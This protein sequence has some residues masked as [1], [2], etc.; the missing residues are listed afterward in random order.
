METNVDSTAS[1]GSEPKNGR[2]GKIVFTVSKEKAIET[3]RRH[4]LRVFKREL[5]NF[6]D[7]LHSGYPDS[8]HL[9]FTHVF[10]PSD[11]N[12]IGVNVSGYEKFKELLQKKNASRNCVTTCLNAYFREHRISEQCGLRKE[13]AIDFKF[14]L[15]TKQSPQT[16]SFPI[17]KSK[18][19]TELK[20][21]SFVF[22]HPSD[23]ATDS[24]FIRGSL[25]DLINGQLHGKPM[26]NITFAFTQSEIDE[27]NG[28]IYHYEL[29]KASKLSNNNPE[30]I[31]VDYKLKVESS[32]VHRDCFKDTSGQLFDLISS[33]EYDPNQVCAQVDRLNRYYL[34]SERDRVIAVKAVI[35]RISFASKNMIPGLN[36]FL[37]IERVFKNQYHI[38]ETVFSSEQAAALIAILL[39]MSISDFPDRCQ[40]NMLTISQ[41]VFKI[42]IGSTFSMAAYL[43]CV[44]ESCLGKKHKIDVVE[45]YLKKNPSDRVILYSDQKE[46]NILCNTIF[47]DVLKGI[48]QIWSIF[49]ELFKNLPQENAFNVLVHI[50]RKTEG[51][52]EGNFTNRIETLLPHVFDYVKKYISERSP[53]DDLDSFVDFIWTL[54]TIPGCV[55]DEM[56]GRIEELLLKYL[57]IHRVKCSSKMFEHILRIL[58]SEFVFVASGRKKELLLAMASSKSKLVRDNFCHICHSFKD[59]KVPF[60]DILVSI[61]EETTTQ[62]IITNICELEEECQNDDELLYDIFKHLKWLL[63]SFEQLTY[64]ENK[65]LEQCLSVIKRSTLESIMDVTKSMDTT[66]KQFQSVVDI[67]TKGISDSINDRCHRT[68]TKPCDIVTRMERE[69]KLIID[70]RAELRVV[71]Q[72]IECCSTNHSEDDCFAIFDEQTRHSVFWESI[73]QAEG[74]MSTELHELNVYQRIT[75]AIQDV[76]N[77]YKSREIF[78]DKCETIVKTNVKRLLKI[79][80]VSEDDIKEILDIIKQKKMRTKEY[81]TIVIDFLNCCTARFP[82]LLGINEGL[83]FSQKLMER[84]DTGAMSL[85]DYK[86]KAF[87]E[88][89]EDLSDISSDLFQVVKSDVFWIVNDENISLFVSLNERLEKQSSLEGNVAIDLIQNL[90]EFLGKECL[91]KYQNAWKRLN[92][93][94][95]ITMK[96]V[97]EILETNCEMKEEISIFEKLY[98]PQTLSDDVKDALLNLSDREKLPKLVSA[99]DAFVK[100]FT[101][102]MTGDDRITKSMDI[103]NNF[104]SDVNSDISLSSVIEDLYRVT[105]LTECVNRKT[106]I[107]IQALGKSVRLVDFIRQ[108]DIENVRTLYDAVDYISETNIEKETIK[109][110]QDVVIFLNPILKKITE[111]ISLD[112]ILHDMQDRINTVKDEKLDSKVNDCNSNVYTLTYLYKNVANRE[113]QTIDVI[114]KI[115]QNGMFSFEIHSR[116]STVTLSVYYNDTV[117]QNKIQ[118]G[119]NKMNDLR[120][121]TLLLKNSLN[122]NEHLLNLNSFLSKIETAFEIKNIM[123]AI[124]DS[125][126]TLDPVL[127][128]GSA[129]YSVKRKLSEQLLDWKTKIDHARMQY[130]LL[131]F[132][133]GRK[134]NILIEYLQNKNPHSK[135]D[136]DEVTT[137]LQF[138]Y[139]GFEQIPVDGE[140]CKNLLRKYIPDGRN[141]SFSQIQVF[142]CILA[143]QL[144]RFTLSNFFKVNILKEGNDNL[145]RKSILE[146]IIQMAN[147]IAARPVQFSENASTGVNYVIANL[148]RIERWDQ[149]NPFACVF[150]DSNEQTI[151]VLYRSENELPYNI[152]NLLHHQLHQG[153]PKYTEMTQEQ[154]YD[155]LHRIL[156]TTSEI[157]DDYVLTPDNLLKMTLIMLRIWASVPVVIMGETGCGKTSLI[158]VLAHACRVPCRVFRLHAGIKETKILEF[159]IEENNECKKNPFEQRWLFIDELNTTECIGVISDLI[160]HGMVHGELLAPNLKI[161]GACNPYK[162]RSILPSQAGGINTKLQNDPLSEL[163]YRVVPLPQSVLQYV[164]DF[165]SLMEK[166][167]HEYIHAMV[168]TLC[169]DSEIKVSIVDAITRSQVFIKS[170]KEYT[171]AVSLRDVNRCLKLMHWFYDLQNLLGKNKDEHQAVI[172]ALVLTYQMRFRERCIRQ[173]YEKVIATPFSISGHEVANIIQSAQKAIVSEMEFP[174]GTAINSILCDN[175]FVLLVCIINKIPV[176]LVG[177]PGSSKSLS[178]QIIQNNLRGLDSKSPLFQNYPCLISVPYQGSE[179]A[180]SDGIE[181]VFK[182]AVSRQH[183]ENDVIAVVILDEIGLSEVSPFNPLKVLHSRLEPYEGGKPEVAVVGLSNWALDAAK[184]NRAIH[185]YIPDMDED[186]LIS[187]ARE[188]RKSFPKYSKFDQQEE[189][190]FKKLAKAYLRYTTEIVNNGNYMYGLRDF[191]A[192]IKHL[193]RNQALKGENK[194]LVMLEGFQRNF[195]GLPEGNIFVKMFFQEDTL[196]L[197]PITNLIRSNINDPLARHLMIISRGNISINIVENIVDNIL[198]RRKEVIV[199]SCFKDDLNDEYYYRVLSRIIFCMEQGHVL[200][201]KNLDPLYGSLYDMLN[202]RYTTVA[203]RKTC[204]VALGQY[205]NPFCHVADGFRCIVFVDEFA[206]NKSDPPFLNRFEKQL[207]CASNI[208]NKQQ[209]NVHQKVANWIKALSCDNVVTSC[210]PCFDEESIISL[211]SYATSVNKD[212]EQ[213]FELCRNLL[214]WL[215]LPDAFVRAHEVLKAEEQANIYLSL[216]I[217]EGLES[218]IQFQQSGQEA[219]LSIELTMVFTFCNIHS[220]LHIPNAVNLCSFQSEKQ[221]TEMVKLFLTETGSDLIIQCDVVSD[222]KLIPLA[223]FILD[224]LKTE[225]KSQI[226]TSKRIYFVMHCRTQK[227]SNT[228][229]ESSDC[230]SGRKLSIYAI[231]FLSG[232][233]YVT[234]D[235][236]EKPSCTIPYFLRTCL[237]ESMETLKPI[238]VIIRE[239]LF[240]SFTRIH[241]SVN[242][243]SIDDIVYLVTRIRDKGSMI[244][245]IIADLVLSNIQKR[246][247]QISSEWVYSVANDQLM[248]LSS[249]S[250]IQALEQYLI[251][252]VKKEI[253]KVVYCFEKFGFFSNIEKLSNTVEFASKQKLLSISSIGDETGPG[254][255]ICTAPNLNYQSAFSHFIYERL[256]LSKSDFIKHLNS[257]QWKRGCIRQILQSAE[258][259][260]VSKCQTMNEFTKDIEGYEH[261]YF[262]LFVHQLNPHYGQDSIKLLK[263]VF[264]AFWNIS[265][266]KNNKEK[267]LFLHYTGWI[268]YHEWSTIIE[269][270]DAF[271]QFNQDEAVGLIDHLKKK[272]KKGESPE[273][274]L[275][276][277]ICN[278]PGPYREVFSDVVDYIGKSILPT[279]VQSD[280]HRWH[281]LV[282]HFVYEA[283]SIS[284]QSR[285]LPSLQLCMEIFCHRKGFESE[286]EVLFSNLCVQL[287]AQ[288]V[289]SPPVLDAVMSIITSIKDSPDGTRTASIQRVVRQ[290]I[291]SCQM[292]DEHSSIHKWFIEGIKSKNLPNNELFRI[293]AMIVHLLENNQG[294][295]L[296][297]DMDDCNRSGTFYQILNECLTSIYNEQRFQ[298]I[299]LVIDI[300]E[301][302]ILETFK[303]QISKELLNDVGLSLL[304]RKIGLRYFI[305]I[306][307]M[308]A[309]VRCIS[310]NPEVIDE[311]LPEV[312]KIVMSLRQEDIFHDLFRFTDDVMKNGSDR[313][314][315]K[316]TLERANYHGNQSIH[317]NPTTLYLLCQSEGQE[318]NQEIL[319]R[320]TMNVHS[321][322]DIKTDEPISN[323]IYFWFIMENVYCKNVDSFVSNGEKT[324]CKELRTILKFEE[325]IG[326]TH[327]FMERVFG[328]MDF[329]VPQ[330]NANTSMTYDDS[331]IAAFLISASALIFFEKCGIADNSILKLCLQNPLKLNFKLPIASPI[332]MLN[333]QSNLNIPCYDVYTCTCQTTIVCFEDQKKTRCIS[334][335]NSEYLRKDAASCHIIGETKD[336]NVFQKMSLLSKEIVLFILKGLILS[337]LA[338]DLVKEENLKT[339]FQSECTHEYIW[340][341]ICCHWGNIRSTFNLDSFDTGLLLY[342]LVVK[343]DKKQAPWIFAD[344]NFEGLDE[345]VS[346]VFKK[347]HTYLERFKQKLESIRHD[348][349]VD[350]HDNTFFRC[351]FRK[352]SF[353]KLEECVWIASL[354]ERKFPFLKFVMDNQ[355]LLQL[356]CHLVR[357]INWHMSVFRNTGRYQI[358]RD[359]TIEKYLRILSKDDNVSSSDSTFD[360]LLESWAILRTCGIPFPFEE[361]SLETKIHNSIILNGNGQIDRVFNFLIEIQNRSL[362]ECG[363]LASQ[364]K[365]LEFLLRDKCACLKGTSVLEIKEHELLHLN[366]EWT[367]IIEDESHS[368]LSEKDGR[369]V[370]YDFYSIEKALVSHLVIGKKYIIHR[371]MPHV[372]FA[373][374]FYKN[375][376]T[377]LKDVSENIR[378]EP[379]PQEIESQFRT[380]CEQDV[381]LA[382]EILSHIGLACA[383]LKTT[384][385]DPISSF[386]DFTCRQNVLKHFPDSCFPDTSMTLKLCHSV[387]LHELMEEVYV[388]SKLLTLVVDKKLF[389]GFLNKYLKQ[390]RVEELE[391]L[392]K[393]L[394]RFVYRKGDTDALDDQ[395][396]INLLSEPCFWSSQTMIN[397]VVRFKDRE[398]KLTELIHNDL[399]VK[400]I[401]SMIGSIQ[402]C[403]K[404]KQ[405]KRKIPVVVSKSETRDPKVF[406]PRRK[407]S[408]IGKI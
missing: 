316:D 58:D 63:E 399:R 78:I 31:H 50:T 65:I 351:V 347:R 148:K 72:L 51:N 253:A 330:L 317:F 292:C 144:K 158:R 291:I 22:D 293:N 339:L 212:T 208:L 237:L 380:K 138:I 341:D 189:N 235:T 69:G 205:T 223:R 246:Y 273:S 94:A 28:K 263:V 319:Q 170:R 175:I 105:Q 42:A 159:L 183:S 16:P 312:I 156:G 61:P 44:W 100:T 204:R 322:L 137:I 81:V 35:E 168:Y 146:T 141:L 101:I 395:R 47:Q 369:K 97:S 213:S 166:D 128:Q 157:P 161:V 66:F 127:V 302:I 405:E 238:E 247:A 271:R 14:H 49:E 143:D 202:Q 283:E 342:K 130:F 337:S 184:M 352:M 32:V 191:Y 218:Y 33:K 355:V 297:K 107:I 398:L 282:Q 332:N 285:S 303:D 121:R 357:V 265:T 400:D 391:F 9:T 389:E 378:Q 220:S 12:W 185:I 73:A 20:D 294:S 270:F 147:D 18:E 83:S 54:K 174:E 364:C 214:L 176:M 19:I 74:R 52:F 199:G 34:N 180:T 217:H 329:R 372:V 82:S 3:I 226:N 26:C 29:H 315:L 368:G 277:I 60:Q 104:T 11:K 23:V 232:W 39:D 155:V 229:T 216:P 7:H 258:V 311:V 313:H 366:A 363:K 379:L 245:K 17:A 289:D 36:L 133:Q 192:L 118:R 306:S 381:C 40:T 77:Q 284:E 4:L 248:L 6:I 370:Y 53:E 365:C 122:E 194:S 321:D 190:D 278:R 304:E 149:R 124:L 221:F 251:S 225:V 377:L 276:D 152:F 335:G 310:I 360:K 406:V 242:G 154:L 76:A 286:F 241:Y 252:V 336:K 373:D 367:H 172:L 279:N 324:K 340:N 407:A 139:S 309:I 163:E 211:V 325:L 92:N 343:S 112:E 280:L 59:L 249:Q 182:K 256:E 326:N 153:P 37:V 353:P 215:L 243:R 165:G 376:C 331:I 350:G 264:N 287:R 75:Q 404:E 383:L 111:K 108:I 203:N 80:N 236:I 210:F 117:S 196:P 5:G 106:L 68:Q 195:N 207:L 261:D 392:Q 46:L 2:I 79:Y 358:K 300:F 338:N 131:T 224:R 115:E 13:S 150:N 254:C 93:T 160:S 219:T 227:L 298:F 275:E 233:K 119:E 142:V 173:E 281:E 132:V 356:P 140:L 64:D 164:W 1:Y 272:Q 250:F 120:S 126:C 259:T 362:A 394:K 179:T 288:S 10:L 56:R 240:W 327:Y 301:S 393:A 87:W 401:A 323:I 382:S 177:K 24:L 193:V 274:V 62:L 299:I 8:K 269:M 385:D 181:E 239:E 27:V 228:I 90:K 361:L 375:I 349:T 334:C 198:K 371:E 348:S 84:L 38:M 103:L 30:I 57:Q 260:L 397:G 102:D 305:S 70:S 296:E 244:Y 188:L 384:K 135:G 151:T 88:D 388:D 129:L 328:K 266:M 125:G 98:A 320:L 402:G 403:L 206:L 43:N 15:K 231:N 110:L 295:I 25:T 222:I 267:V 209:T 114:S 387:A 333:G 71:C 41:E 344:R 408:K 186:E 257:V 386:Q 116:C 171:S 45:N 201:L 123:E 109:S 230:V 396:V 96:E 178:I 85:K 354:K 86:S 374:E 136:E 255:Y 48:D 113:E 359:I 346:G 307:Y 390:F 145:V 95:N 318:K 162:K 197:I 262:L 99:I 234:I 91:Q 55:N 345:E 167:E 67:L 169:K 308:R 200:I 187:T 89:Y 134:I 21:V 268:F 290:C 314:V